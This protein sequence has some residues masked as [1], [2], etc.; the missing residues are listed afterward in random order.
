MGYL[1]A[2]VSDLQSTPN[3]CSHDALPLACMSFVPDC[4]IPSREI[5]AE[6]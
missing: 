5:N 6:C 3:V 1:A 4:F 2:K